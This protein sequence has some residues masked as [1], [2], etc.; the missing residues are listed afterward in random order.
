ML[1]L[2]AI[3]AFI[4]L[5]CL[6]FQ[7]YWACR[8]VLRYSQQSAPK[9]APNS[10]PRATVLLCIRGADPSL[11]NCLDGLLHQD[12]PHYDIRIVIDSADDPAWDI[13]RSIL[14]REDLPSVKVN[15][16]VNRHETCSLKLSALVQ[17]IGEL[18]E[19]TEVVAL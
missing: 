12:Y 13:I 3:S 19:S 7:V 17:A 11:F 16:L 8:F 15:V 4:A 18:D 5:F 2:A 14:A 10:W 6:A 1:S 9:S